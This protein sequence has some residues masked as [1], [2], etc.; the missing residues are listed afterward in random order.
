MDRFTEERLVVRDE[1]R[2]ERRRHREGLPGLLELIRRRLS[3]RLSD[4]NR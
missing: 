2:R 1:Y 3:S 4:E